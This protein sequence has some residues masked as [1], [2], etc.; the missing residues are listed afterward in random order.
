MDSE[1]KRPGELFSSDTHTHTNIHTEQGGAGS[2]PD[3]VI[4]S[5]MF[6]K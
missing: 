5:G 6:S 1:L 2:V 3:T 4:M